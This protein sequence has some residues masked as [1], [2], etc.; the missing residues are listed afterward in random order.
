MYAI[1]LVK[2]ADIFTKLPVPSSSV[3]KINLV[4]HA[5]GDSAVFSRT[6]HRG[7]CVR[8]LATKHS[9]IILSQNFVHVADT[10]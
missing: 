6:F 9:Q 2:L 1:Q 10:A 4:E 3:H 7:S 5:F 8:C